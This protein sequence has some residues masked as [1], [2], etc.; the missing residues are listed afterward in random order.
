M[1]K[2]QD[3]EKLSLWQGRL[4]A[5]DSAYSKYA[6]KMDEREAIYKGTSE[7]TQIVDG[8]KITA[9]PHIRNIASEL[10]EAQMDSGIPKPKVTAKRKKDENLAKL[11]ED[12]LIDELDRMPFEEINDIMG[13][14][15]PI[16]GG[17]IY[18]LEWDNTKRTHTTVGELKVSAI[19]PK[20]IVPQDGVFSG[21]E[22]MDYIFLKLSQT[23]SFIK[24]RYGVDVSDEAEAEPDIKGSD[25]AGAADDMVTQYVAYYRNERGGIGLFSWVNDTVL[26]D[27]EDYQARRLRKCAQCGAA[28]PPQDILPT[29]EPS[30]DGTFPGGEL[31]P[32]E[33]GKC[34]YC[35]GSKWEV[36]SEEY[37]ELTQPIMKTDGTVIESYESQTIDT[38][39][40][41]E[42]GETVTEQAITPV[43]VPYYTPNIYPVILQKN[44]SVFGQFLGDS[45]IDKIQ[46]QQNTINRL[47]AKIIE[48]LLKSG[49]YVTLPEDAMIKI[50]SEDMKTIRLLSPA[51]K[52]M[53]DVIT[54]QGD[55][56]QDMAYLAQT[57]EESRQIIGVTDSFQGRADSTATS[58]KAK[59]FAANQTAGRLESK[60]V[61][62]DA[63][64]A[65]LYE[66]M[67][68]FKLAY[69]DEPRPVLSRDIYG[70]TEYKEF[71]RYDFLEKD[72]AGQWYWNDQF[73]FSCDTS[74]PLATN[75]EAM[76]QET[77]ENLQTGAFGDPTSLDTLIM[78]WSKMQ[79][80]HYPG[81]AETKKQLEELQ[82]KQSQQAQMA[83]QAQ[84][85][86][87][88][89]M[90]NQT[91]QTARADARRGG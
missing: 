68:K 17:G 21:I 47:E 20:R 1:A 73:L 74:A 45:D 7:I 69:A 26:E 53:I 2:K 52:A 39:E 4:S 30:E 15:V 27:L 51:D 55:I 78:F 88:E 3:K 32:R 40:T 9:T 87:Q 61:M 10:I 64:F 42:F 72:A 65:A 8:D 23:K 13:R 36:S 28:E 86:M 58:G 89:Q 63:A 56:S 41:D 54:V 90:M 48:K 80:L 44:V 79:M 6:G 22:D 38:G 49:S 50:D 60:R 84:A 70:N 29:E 19:H 46:T 75:R 31:K 24:R 81:A 11:I 66:A 16:Q 59:E 43:R 14:T 33:T 83:A 76:W 91:I 18:L 25:G 12:M 37:E 5:A 57:Y 62:K 35:G 82:I 34:P 67:F 85:Q 77:R 71:N